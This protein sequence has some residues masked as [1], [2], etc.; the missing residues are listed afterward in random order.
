MLWDSKLF[1]QD[2]I[3]IN[4]YFLADIAPKSF[5]ALQNRLSCFHKTLESTDHTV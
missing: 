3:L 1:S 4:M 5:N 2:Y